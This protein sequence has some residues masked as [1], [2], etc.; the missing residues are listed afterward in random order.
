MEA[1]QDLTRCGLLTP[2]FLVVKRHRAYAEGLRMPCVV[3]QVYIGVNKAIAQCRAEGDADG[4]LR[5]VRKQSREGGAASL[6]FDYVNCS[7]WLN[8]CVRAGGAVLRG[9]Y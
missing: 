9:T 8:G 2:H 7:T 5:I 6:E 4:L 1:R 3:A